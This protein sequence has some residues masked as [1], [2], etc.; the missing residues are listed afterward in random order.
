[1]VQIVW[2]LNGLPSHVTL[3]FEYC[4]PILSGIQVFSIQ[5]VTVYRSQLYLKKFRFQMLWPPLENLT[6]KT[7][8]LLSGFGMVF[9]KMVA[10]IE[11]LLISNF[12]LIK[13]A[14]L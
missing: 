5:M 12:F 2:Y 8:E 11:Q 10:I 14:V 3:P 1:M 6:F 4:T 13:Q 9:E 7:Q